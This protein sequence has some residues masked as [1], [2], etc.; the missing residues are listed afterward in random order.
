MLVAGTVYKL[1][2]SSKVKFNFKENVDAAFGPKSPRHALKRL[3]IRSAVRG[4]NISK[5]EKMKKKTIVEIV[6]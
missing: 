1:A 2:S 6:A 5:L 4:E 3:V